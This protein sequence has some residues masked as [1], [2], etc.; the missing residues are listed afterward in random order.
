MNPPKIFAVIVGI[1]E[2]HPKFGGINLSACVYDAQRMVAGPLLNTAYK[3]ITNEQATHARVEKI[4]WDLA[5]VAQPGDTVYYFQSG[6]GTYTDNTAGER[7][8]GRV[9]YDRVWWDFQFVETLEMFKAGVTVILLSDMCHAESNSRAAMP[10]GCRIKSAQVERFSTKP[11]KASTKNVKCSV[12]AI[13]ACLVDETAKEL[14]EGSAF[15]RGG[16]FTTAL[17]K[18]ANRKFSEIAS[19]VTVQTARYQQ[20]VKI[21]YVNIPRAV[22]ARKVFAHL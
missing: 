19:K 5:M 12:V 21:D 22:K 8:T 3:V 14:P 13:G 11:T 7:A 17:L 18:E 4:L 9:M 2:Y 10:K 20:R 6:H 15:G 1:D 16:V